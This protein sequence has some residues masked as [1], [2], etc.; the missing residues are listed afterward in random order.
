MRKVMSIIGTSILVSSLVMASAAQS[1]Q[2]VSNKVDSKKLHKIEPMNQYQNVGG[3]S[4]IPVQHNSRNGF[5]SVQVDESKNGYGMIVA[6]TKPLYLD[7]N[8]GLLFVYRQWAG[9]AG[10]SGQIGATLCTDCTDGTVAEGTT[11]LNLNGDYEIGRYPSA[12]GTGDYPYAIWNEYTG[13]GNPSYGGRPF[14]AYD[15]FDWDGGSFTDPIDLDNAWTTDKDLWVGSPSRSISDG[16]EMLNVAYAD[17]TRGDTWL[18]HSE[19]YAEDGTIIFGSEIK[20]IDETADLVGGDDEGSYT[21]SP[22]LHINQDGIGYFA[23]TAYFSGADQDASVVDDATS[24]TIVFKQTTNHGA[25]WGPGSSISPTAD[26][27]YYINDDVYQHMMDSGVVPTGWEDPDDCPDSEPYSWN[28]LFLTYDFDVKADS[29]G[30]PHFIVGMLPTDGEYV[31]PSLDPS[32]GLYHFW[33]D[34]DHLDNPGDPQTATG[35]NYSYVAD[36]HDTWA[37]TDAGGN[38]FWQWTFPSLA[39]SEG[40]DGDETMY[41]VAS[42]VNEGPENDPDGDPCTYDSEYLEWNM[43]TYVMKSE[44]G[45]E[46]WW[47][48]YNATN[49]PDLDPTDEGQPDE[50]FAHAASQAD[51]D[52]VYMCFQMPD[53]VYGSTTGD[54]GMADN[55][56]N[57]YIGYATLTSAPACDEGGCP[58]D[59]GDS[60][61]DGTLNI[62]DIVGMVNFILG[63]GSIGVECAAD[64][65]GDGTIN[66]L[67]IVGMVN[68]ILGTGSCGDSRS[69]VN[70]ATQASILSKNGVVSISANGDIGAVQIELKHSDDFSI[71]LTEDALLSEYNT[72]GNKTTLIILAPEGK[73]LFTSEGD[74]SIIDVSVANSTGTEF[75]STNVAQEYAVMSNYPNPFNPSTTVNYEVFSDGFVKLSVYNVVGQEIV[76]L[77]NSVV[78]SG[79]HTAVWNGLDN[80]GNEVSSG[81]Y[82]LQLH[83]DNKVISNKITLLR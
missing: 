35:W 7:S 25:S 42:R 63:T 33:I 68:C 11:Y 66:I 45:G 53:Y 26:K 55:K 29:D 19:A 70:D 50:T 71:E 21:S 4:G 1:N 31:Y 32:Q 65:N 18:F 36:M 75:V 9:E 82:L 79:E 52:G 83:T 48:P 44:D 78:A 80:S 69:V 6:P 13:T 37:W 46:T 72:V 57:V 28:K 8:Q 34:K 20:V 17:W 56:Q 61:G 77:V 43:D 14:Y 3:E 81:V 23:V 16:M 40:S 62:L 2:R 27:Y 59:L 5:E 30:N 74:F 10:T 41:V 60:N 76:S 51:D 39:F 22:N 47:C 49:T 54:A 58:A 24:H 73:D 64:F 15:D 38:S 67:D 12:L